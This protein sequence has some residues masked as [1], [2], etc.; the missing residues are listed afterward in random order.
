MEE[1]RKG[2]SILKIYD[3]LGQEG[4]EEISEWLLR[5]LCVTPLI[6][7][8]INYI[9]LLDIPSYDPYLYNFRCII[10]S[11]VGFILMTVFILFF[12]IGK[13]MHEHLGVK[14][15]LVKVK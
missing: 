7:G 9:M 3:K 2:L 4:Y 6:T 8:I 5:L 14:E 13:I 11:S 1:K 10:V 12:I 15:I